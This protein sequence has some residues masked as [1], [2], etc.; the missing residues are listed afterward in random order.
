MKT[1]MLA[2]H[3][4]RSVRQVRRG[5]AVY[6]MVVG[7]TL[8]VS[9]IGFSALTVSRL[10]L[11]STTEGIDRAEAQLLAASAVENARSPSTLKS[12]ICWSTVDPLNAPTSA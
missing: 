10:Q 6:M 11:R 8:I 4:E 9:A 7:L 5:T 12:S 2:H 3:P 1:D